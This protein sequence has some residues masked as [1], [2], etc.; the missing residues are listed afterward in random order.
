MDVNSDMSPLA[1]AFDQSIYP[2]DI[3]TPIK[4][5]GGAE[6][7][8]WH[9]LSFTCFSVEDTCNRLTI[10]GLREDSPF[11]A[12]KGI[13]VKSGEH[14][15]RPYYKNVADSRCILMFTFTPSRNAI[16][17]FMFNG[18]SAGHVLDFVPDPIDIRF[19]WSGFGGFQDITIACL[20]EPEV[21]T[22]TGAAY[23][24]SATDAIIRQS[25]VS[26]DE[27]DNAKEVA[28]SMSDVRARNADITEPDVTTEV[29]VPNGPHVKAKTADI[30]ESDFTTEAAVP[31]DPHVK[32]ITTDVTESGATTEAGVP[33]E[34]YV[35][36]KNADITEPD[37]TTEGTIAIEP[38]IK[39]KTAIITEPAVTTE[40]VVPNEPRVKAKTDDI[41]EPG[42]TT[43]GAVTIETDVTLEA[44]LNNEPHVTLIEAVPIE[45][46][47]TT[48]AV[49]HNGLTIEAATPNDLNVKTQT[50][51]TTEPE[52]ATGNAMTY[53]PDVTIP[54]NIESNS[55]PQG[56]RNTTSRVS[57]DEINQSTG[58]TSKCGR[59]MVENLQGECIVG[60]TFQLGITFDLPWS[61]GLLMTNSP[62]YTQMES[63]I[64]CS[65][66]R[67]FSP[68]LTVASNLTN[69]TPGSIVANLT[70]TV[71]PGNESM[72]DY[73][74]TL[75]DIL[76][77]FNV[78]RASGGKENL[79][80]TPDC[81]TSANDYNECTDQEDL[82]M[83][84]DAAA[85]CI[86]TIGS[87]ECVCPVGTIDVS[88]YPRFPG[89]KCS[90][91]DTDHDVLTIVSIT[92]LVGLTIVCIIACSCW[93]Y[94]KRKQM[95]VV[96]ERKFIEY[97]NKDETRRMPMSRPPLA[98]NNI[99]GMG[100]SGSQSRRHAGV[101]GNRE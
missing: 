33:N 63:D 92:C 30:T 18:Q 15:N 21:A 73:N 96:S 6:Y 43:E 83:R 71:A 8:P 26:A 16:W 25:F 82:V 9:G 97:F 1:V 52:A 27:P 80:Y 101:Y 94:L 40:A 24:F 85:R 44:V 67:G 95:R 23:A 38:H 22:M 5:L 88:P 58:C 61:D 35:K 34:P 77:A 32:A 12:V 91:R 41:T 36:A 70:V 99:N 65:I 89:R 17:G 46:K 78:R 45:P 81:I 20:D 90:Y 76:R 4:I 84:C 48:E 64:L 79:P 31:N 39:T 57:P 49:V 13:Y 51:S 66:R 37:F 68:Q 53:E 47:I 93:I 19:Q 54:V 98:Y 87:F 60:T 86:N 74:V 3:T 56:A 62:M 11:K 69:F 50:A 42:V 29:A 7:T 10:N 2:E 59:G 14:H 28:T 55:E 75:E 72:V 100:D